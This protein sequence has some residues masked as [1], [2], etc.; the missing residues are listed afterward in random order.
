MRST[1]PFVRL[2][3]SGDWQ[4]SSERLLRDFKL[5]SAPLLDCR[6]PSLANQRTET[7]HRPPA[8]ALRPYGY[9]GAWKKGWVS[10]GKGGFRRGVRPLGGE[11]YT[12]IGR[13]HAWTSRT[14]Q[15]RM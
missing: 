6:L 10:S 1:S 3:P 9:G 11:G 2:R 5:A 8:T 4:G 7:C 14:S 13:G 15:K 12:E